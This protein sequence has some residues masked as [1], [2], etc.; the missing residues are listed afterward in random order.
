MSR[1]RTLSYCA[2]CAT[3]FLAIAAAPILAAPTIVDTNWSL[4]QTWP[5]EAAWSVAYNSFEGLAYAIER[6]TT[7]GV[8]RLNAD[9]T[10]TKIVSSYKGGGLTFDP[11][12]GDMFLA[13]DYCGDI[14]RVEFGQTTRS[15]WVSDYD[16][17]ESD[18]AGLATVPST[19]TGGLVAPGSALATDRGSGNPDELWA[20]SPDTAEGETKLIS[21]FTALNDP[22]DVAVNDNHIIVIDGGATGQLFEL[23][24][25]PS[26]Q[27]YLEEIATQTP[28][29]NAEA[30]VFDP[31]TGDLLMTVYDS[32]D[33]NPSGSVLRINLNTGIVSTIISGLDDP[34]WGCLDITPDGK[35]LYVTEYADGTTNGMAYEFTVPEPMSISLFA[36]GTIT[37]LR[38]RRRKN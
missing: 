1:E 12:D 35:T 14:F 8:H 38:S 31:I 27:L 29:H 13:E 36:L 25:Y 6:T 28:L 4:T 5:V 2:F 37:L 7:G 33:G 34:R 9:G 30:A 15:T 19:Y 32:L 22:F 26:D 3:C 16:G 20:W 17:G 24:K 11:D 18:I 10:T 21:D 23:K